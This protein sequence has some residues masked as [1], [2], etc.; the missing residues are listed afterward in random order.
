MAIGKKGKDVDCRMY[1][2]GR[3]RFWRFAIIMYLESRKLCHVHILNFEISGN[4]TLQLNEIK[5]KDDHR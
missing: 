2:C 5:D 3:H 1:K 4:T